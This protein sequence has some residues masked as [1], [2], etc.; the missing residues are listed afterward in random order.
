MRDRSLQDLSSPLPTRL[1]CGHSTPA[2]L[3]ATITK[4]NKTDNS[5]EEEQM[6]KGQNS[7]SS[8]DKDKAEAMDSSK[9]GSVSGSRS[10]QPSGNNTSK[11]DDISNSSELAKLMELLAKPSKQH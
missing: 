10:S 9:N 1:A 7:E 5:L 3:T 4:E 2:P 8:A 6:T 11:D